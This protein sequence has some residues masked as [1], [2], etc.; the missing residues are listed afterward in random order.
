VET[1]AWCSRLNETARVIELASAL[2]VDLSL[3]DL[4]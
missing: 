1:Y 2:P 4:L 3:P